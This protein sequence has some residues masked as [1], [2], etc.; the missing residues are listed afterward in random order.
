M[1]SA[2]LAEKGPLGRPAAGAEAAPEW[3]TKGKPRNGTSRKR[4]PTAVGVGNI[5]LPQYR[6]GSFSPAV[7]PR[8]VLASGTRNR[9][10]CKENRRPPPERS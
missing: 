1:S 4:V 5:E 3:A 8:H 6:N 7:A 2:P 10:Q 9:R